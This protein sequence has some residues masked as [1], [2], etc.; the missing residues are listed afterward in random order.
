MAVKYDKMHTALQDTGLYDNIDSDDDEGEAVEVQ[1]DGDVK[2]V[3][4]HPVLLSGSSLNTFKDDMLPAMEKLRTFFKVIQKDDLDLSGAREC[5]YMAR[6]HP[7]LKGHSKDFEDRLL[8][9]HKLVVAPL[10][11]LGV[12]KIIE[13]NNED[14]TQDEKTAC[15]PLLKSNWKSLYK[16]QPP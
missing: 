1:E 10:F 6:N 15:E 16:K 4:I 14:L 3:K 2:T 11:E 8:P 12:C 7:K 13:G 5:F 9:T